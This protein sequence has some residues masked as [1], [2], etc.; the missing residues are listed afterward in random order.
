MDSVTENTTVLLLGEDDALFQLS[1][2]LDLDADLLYTTESPE[3]VVSVA[4]EAPVELVVI[5]EFDE[6][7]LGADEVL[8]GINRA[9]EDIYTVVYTGHG[10]DT[11]DDSN[12]VRELVDESLVRTEH[13]ESKLNSIVSNHV[14]VT[15]KGKEVS[16]EPIPADAA[17]NQDI[18]GRFDVQQARDGVGRLVADEVDSVDWN[19]AYACLY[20]RHGVTVLATD[21]VD[22][23]VIPGEDPFVAYTVTSDCG[24]DIFNCDSEQ[25]GFDDHPVVADVGCEEVAVAPF[26]APS[27]ESVGAICVGL[28]FEPEVSE[29]ATIQRVAAGAVE[30]VYK[31][32][33]ND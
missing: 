8:D 23:D 3:D 24:V 4:K 31:C 25:V 28:A 7:P 12:A 21:S 17:L 22:T 33:D 30:I 26:V 20:G 10:V 13:S 19:W 6:R 29:L 1:L 11:F 14:S 18:S 5:T 2:S 32:I 9:D 15:P 27:G 16:P